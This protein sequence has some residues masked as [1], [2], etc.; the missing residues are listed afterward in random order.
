FT[1]DRTNSTYK[2]TFASISLDPDTPLVQLNGGNTI[3][4]VTMVYNGSVPVSIP[5]ENTMHGTAHN[6]K[7]E[8]NLPALNVQVTNVNGDWT[9]DSIS[10]E[11]VLF[12][13]GGSISQS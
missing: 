8:T 3:P 1:T 7:L 11:F 10:G 12:K 5:I 13:D 9:Y 2:S 6:F 4:T